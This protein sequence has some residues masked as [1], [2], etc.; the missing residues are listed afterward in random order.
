MKPVSRTVHE[1]VVIQGLWE[2]QL[3]EER[4]KERKKERNYINSNLNALQLDH[5]KNLK[6][7]ERKKK[8]REKRMLE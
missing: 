8:E 5:N 2:R 7:K 3:Y 4:K 6:H 1:L